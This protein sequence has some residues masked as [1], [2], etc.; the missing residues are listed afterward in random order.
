LR[1]EEIVNILQNKIPCYLPVMN[2]CPVIALFYNSLPK[3]PFDTLFISNDIYVGD[4][5]KI[6]GGDYFLNKL[7]FLIK[8][9]SDKLLYPGITPVQG[10][11]KLQFNIRDY[12]IYPCNKEPASKRRFYACEVGFSF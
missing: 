4:L 1:I 12:F 5:S 6:I 8:Q 11:N 3:R 10:F 2:E 7:F 9:T